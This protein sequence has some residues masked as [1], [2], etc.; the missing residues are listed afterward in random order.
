MVTRGHTG[1]GKGTSDTGNRRR[2]STDSRLNTWQGNLRLPTSPPVPERALQA[3]LT[4]IL[5]H[6]LQIDQQL[7]NV[8]ARHKAI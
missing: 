8:L 6:I 7:A 3:Q 4:T 2:G 5:L 1:K